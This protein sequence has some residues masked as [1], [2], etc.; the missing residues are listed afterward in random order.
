MSGLDLGKI[1]DIIYDGKKR[2][3][4]TSYISGILKCFGF[5]TLTEN[6]GVHPENCID[7]R[8]DLM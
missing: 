6:D 1:K 4:G 8:P 2:L 7:R 5:L 3:P